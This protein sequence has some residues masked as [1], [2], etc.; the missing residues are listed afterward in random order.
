MKKLVVCGDSFM[1]SM[2]YNELDLDNGYNSHFTELLAK[3]LGWD[4]ITFAMAG[5]DNQTIRL[6]I[7]ES[8]KENPDCVIIGTTSTDR[9][10]LP[11]YNSEEYYNKFKS[12]DN[13]FNINDGLYNIDYT[14][15]Q[16]KSSTNKFKKTNHKFITMLNSG[17]V[18]EN[19]LNLK[20]KDLEF[21]QFWYE[22][23]YDS[24]LKKLQDSWIISNGLRKLKDNNINFFCINNFLISSELEVY[25][26]SIIN[27]N[28]EL[29][30]W[31]YYKEDK[32]LFH[33]TLESQ[34]I[35]A[36]KWYELFIKSDVKKFI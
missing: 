31:R 35:L 24:N 4:V 30:P 22:R 1:A 17:L 14:K 12:N 7:D 6:Q 3:K 8:I 15:T 18:F 5:C 23:F 25:G 28:S 2:S 27:Y 13:L 26:D 19:K 21:L 11:L 10:M 34:V 32:Y 36:N 16:N 9:M 29:N 20:K 33:T